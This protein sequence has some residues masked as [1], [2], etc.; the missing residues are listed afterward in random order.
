MRKTLLGGM[1]E[2]LLHTHCFYLYLGQIF[3]SL[4][5]FVW[6]DTPLQIFTIDLWYMEMSYLTLVVCREKRRT[7]VFGFY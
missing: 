3:P 5:P 2:T 6:D 7:F 4:G 1:K